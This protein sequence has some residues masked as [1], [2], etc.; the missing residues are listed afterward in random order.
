[1]SKFNSSWILKFSVF[2]GELIN[3]KSVLISDLFDSVEQIKERFLSCQ[4]IETSYPVN[5]SGVRY[6]LGLPST[7]CEGCICRILE[8]SEKLRLW[9]Y[10]HLDL[11][12]YGYSK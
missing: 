8:R 11:V 4:L 9:N 5:F 6:S 3:V 1:M 10:Y 7:I 2:R 12:Y